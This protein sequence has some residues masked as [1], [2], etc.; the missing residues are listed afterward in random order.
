MTR[1]PRVKGREEVAAHLGVLGDG[2][3]RS[4]MAGVDVVDDGEEDG[5]RDDDDAGAVHGSYG[6]A[7]GWGRRGRRRGSS[8]Q[9]PG[10]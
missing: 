8:P 9:A 4:E 10:R 5:R 7:S 1:Q 3:R 6:E 2:L